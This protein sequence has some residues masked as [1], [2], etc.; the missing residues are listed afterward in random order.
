MPARQTSRALKYQCRKKD[1]DTFGDGDFAA[2]A[3][4]V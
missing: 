1:M 3:I 4:M 2:L